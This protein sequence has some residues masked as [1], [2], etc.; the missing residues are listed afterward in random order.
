MVY[1][2]LWLTVLV[3]QTTVALDDEDIPPEAWEYVPVQIVI[4]A[5]GVVAIWIGSR[6]RSWLARRS[7]EPS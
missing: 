2:P 5:V 1:I 7:V 4:F 3:F 6:A